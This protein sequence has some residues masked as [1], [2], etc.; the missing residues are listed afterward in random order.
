MSGKGAARL[1]AIALALS[2]SGCTDTTRAPDLAKAGTAAAT[3]LAAYYDSLIQA[4]FDSWDMEIFYSAVTGVEFGKE[5]E[6]LLLA[7]VDALR[8]RA[9]MAR[10]LAG[11]YEA[12]GNL[13][14]SKGGGAPDAAAR[15]GASLQAIPQMPA[16]PLKPDGLFRLVAGRLVAMRQ[17][18]DLLAGSGAMAETLESVH[19]LIDD[20]TQVYQGVGAE[21]DK[22]I[23]TLTGY[24]M[25]HR[26]VPITPALRRIPELLN[27]EWQDTSRLVQDEKV[28]EAAVAL[29]VTDSR[30]ASLLSESAI[31][32]VNHSL[33]ALAGLH[34]EL[35]GRGP[36]NLDD[37]L[38]A[39]RTAESDLDEI[40]KL[41]TKPKPKPKK[42]GK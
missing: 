33:E 29:A 22:N 35:G 18:R 37:V 19:K 10:Q 13:A 4:S 1:A 31:G 36:M 40:E 6:K 11:A 34:R 14:A 39:V 3:A 23:Q 15:L 38:R 5:E 28:V 26:M 8:Q 30:R 42:E 21:R 27:L 7:R 32:K 16:S 24:L 17:S 2:L 20:E 12:L 25:R 41:R 9:K